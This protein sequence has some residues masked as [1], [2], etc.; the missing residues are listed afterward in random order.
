VGT[1]LALLVPTPLASLMLP[2]LALRHCPPLGFTHPATPEHW[3]LL[4]G[5]PY[6]VALGW[7]AG[8]H[9]ISTRVLLPPT[10]TPHGPLR[11]VHPPRPDRLRLTRE[12]DILAAIRTALAAPPSDAPS[13]F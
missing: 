2:I 7:P 9:R 4:G 12:I 1:A 10:V 3:V 8:V 6:P 11:W 5:E 13:A